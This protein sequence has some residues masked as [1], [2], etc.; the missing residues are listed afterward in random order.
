MNFVVLLLVLV[1]PEHDNAIVTIVVLAG[2]GACITVTEI[3]GEMRERT[4]VSDEQLVAAM[5]SPILNHSQLCSIGLVNV[6]LLLRPSQ[7]W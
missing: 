6:T 5:T 1:V 2:A 7:W 4:V 3:S